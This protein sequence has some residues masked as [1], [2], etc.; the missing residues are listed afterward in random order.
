MLLDI[1][2][3]HGLV[4][5]VEYSKLNSLIVA[6][7]AADEDEIDASDKEEEE[8]EEEQDEMGRIIK[9]TVDYVIRLDK[10]ELS[11]LLMEFAMK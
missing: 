5:A 7:P 2:L 6:P 4:T 9:E 10:E 3:D 8:K 1:M 11:G